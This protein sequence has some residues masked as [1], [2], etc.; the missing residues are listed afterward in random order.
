MSNIGSRPPGSPVSLVAPA[1]STAAARRYLKGVLTDTGEPDNTLNEDERAVLG[2]GTLNKRWLH[3]TVSLNDVGS[4]CEW[5]L[6]TFDRFSG[7]WSLD[8]RPGTSG[9]VAL[10]E[11][12][13]DNPQASIIEI[14]GKD[15]VFIELV[16]IAAIGAEGIDVWLA[17]SGQVDDG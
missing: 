14:A 1:A 7:L 5:K 2:V 4:S 12:D 9:V 13:A 16:N 10:A 6:W 17:G 15:R 3:V 11:S 8:T